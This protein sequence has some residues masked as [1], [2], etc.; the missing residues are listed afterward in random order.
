MTIYKAQSALA[1]LFLRTPQ[2]AL[3]APG[4]DTI[5]LPINDSEAGG[6]YDQ[7]FMPAYAGATPEGTPVYIY[8]PAGTPLDGSAPTGIKS[9]DPAFDHTPSYRVGWVTVPLVNDAGET[10]TTNDDPHGNNQ[11]GNGLTGTSGGA[12]FVDDP[13]YVHYTAQLPTGATDVRFRYSTDAAYLDTGW[14]V[15]DVKVNGADASLSSPEGEWFET[16]GIQENNWT[17]QITAG[18]DLTP[19]SDSAGEIV[20][21]E[22]NHVYRLE[23]DSVTSPVLDT[24]CA[25]GPNRD[26][27]VIVSN[28]P[29]GDLT[30]LNADYDLRIRKATAAG[31][32]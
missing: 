1:A 7:E 13:V 30:V 5:I 8:V 23:G 14:F 29:T 10:V 28:L 32:R 9:L 22:G 27:A 4:D 11:E 17:V 25:N 31:K 18:C 16:T 3:A 20:D 15:D 24:K 19:G 2:A 12:Y 26:F 21:S 6:T